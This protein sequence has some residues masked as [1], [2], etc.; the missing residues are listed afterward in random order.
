MTQCIA[1]TALFRACTKVT[2]GNGIKT[3]FWHDRWLQGQTPQEVAPTHLCYAWRK[4]GSVADALRD[5]NCMKGL[6]R[7]CTTE[8][9]TQF[10]SLWSKIRLV[11]LSDQPD[12]IIW[13][14]TEHGNYTASSAYSAQFLGS[15][16]DGDWSSLWKGRAENKCKLFA[17]LLM[18]TNYGQRTGY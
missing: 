13:R 8:E 12:Q 9:V 4:N 3:K 10:V 2:V 7:I 1:E 11:Q 14:F 15:F 5:G 6:T 17:W 18:Q 16:A